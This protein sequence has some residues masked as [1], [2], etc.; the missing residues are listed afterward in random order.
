MVR[1]EQ[2]RPPG[3]GGDTF[4]QRPGESTGGTPNRPA[5]SVGHALAGPTSGTYTKDGPLLMIE[6]S[7]WT[8]HG[9][10]AGA[11]FGAVLPLLHAEPMGTPTEIAA[12][13]KMIVG[14]SASTLPRFLLPN[15][16]AP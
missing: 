8:A 6:A 7:G 15:I 16:A 14:S 2:I 1:R 11:A 5:S 10:D 9:S 13:S 4:V 3:S 12:A